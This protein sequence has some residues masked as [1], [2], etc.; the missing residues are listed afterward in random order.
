M[1]G[2]TIAVGGGYVAIGDPDYSSTS[3][4][5]DVY[6]LNNLNKIVATISPPEEN[7]VGFGLAI[8]ISDNKMLISD[9][10]SYFGDYPYSGDVYVYSL[11]N[12]SYITKLEQTN[13]ERAY[14]NP[15]GYSVAFCGQHI[16]V[17]APDQTVDDAIYAGRAFIYSSETYACEKTI[18]NPEKNP[19]ATA[20]GQFG[21][22]IA[23]TSDKIWISETGYIYPANSENNEIK[24]AGRVYC[25]NPNG[26]LL[27]TLNT[28]NPVDGGFFG[29]A[30][31]A[32][33]QY[34]IVGAPGEEAKISS[35]TETT[36]IPYA[37]QVYIFAQSSNLWAIWKFSCLWK[38]ILHSWS[39][40]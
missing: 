1:V 4:K 39:T 24:N 18:A 22:S 27:T 3:F 10:G 11:P 14:G 26:E 16:I 19:K 30:I 29:R 20:W 17:G 37:G 12:F 15:F 31:V 34:V 2:S 36:T 13:P 28:Q 5:V 33:D 21:K 38:W 23:A 6:R 35:N 8:A 32:N 7:H 40:R 9:I 25:Y